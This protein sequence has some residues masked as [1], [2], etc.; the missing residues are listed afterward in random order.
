MHEVP[1]DEEVTKGFLEATKQVKKQHNH[2]RKEPRTSS[3]LKS[4]LRNE[5]IGQIVTAAGNSQF[6][7]LLLHTICIF[8]NFDGL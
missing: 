7:F 3:D 6:V 1:G 5:P 2:E 8:I 4:A